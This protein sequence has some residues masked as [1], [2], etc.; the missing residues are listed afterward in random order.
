MHGNDDG[1]DDMMVATHGGDAGDEWGIASCSSAS[2]NL[3][4]QSLANRRQQSKRQ[5][6]DA[7]A[8]AHSHQRLRHHRQCGQINAASTETPP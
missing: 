5:R 3:G 2:C 6:R 4:W 1:D 7:P 8:M